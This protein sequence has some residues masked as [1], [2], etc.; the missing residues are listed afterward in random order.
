MNLTNRIPF[1]ATNNR[2][3]PWASEFVCCESAR[4][5]IPKIFTCLVLFF[6]SYSV[7]F[8]KLCWESTYAVKVK[9]RR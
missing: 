2:E 8:R 4:K 3:N 7:H 9:E 5:I 6:D 1:F